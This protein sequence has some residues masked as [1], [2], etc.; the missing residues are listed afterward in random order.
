MKKLSILLLVT[1]MVALSPTSTSAQIIVISDFDGT[2]FDVYSGAP[3]NWNAGA[4]VGPEFLTISSPAVAPGNATFSTFLVPIPDLTGTQ[5]FRLDL[6]LVPGNATDFLSF[7]LS[8]L[9]DAPGVTTWQFSATELNTSTFTTKIFSL[10]APTTSTG[11]VDLENVTTIFFGGGTFD[12][13]GDPF[14]MQFDDL[15]AVGSVPEPGTAATT[16]GG[17]VWFLLRRRRRHARSAA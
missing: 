13:E 14:G 12:E 16:G 17:I 9:G 15:L 10:A 7:G 8:Y 6:R 3:A 11:M 2:G 1:V 5:E 4:S